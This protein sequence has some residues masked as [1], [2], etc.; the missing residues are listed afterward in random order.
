MP[1]VPKAHKANTRPQDQF[2]SLYRFQKNSMFPLASGQSSPS[3]RST[4]CRG[5]KPL[6]AYCPNIGR[7]IFCAYSSCVCINQVMTIYSIHRTPTNLM[8]FH[9]LLH[10]IEKT[11]IILSCVRLWFWFMYLCN[12]SFH[13]IPSSSSDIVRR[14]QDLKKIFHLVFKLLR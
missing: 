5:Q 9:S 2:V 12:F 4:S 1:K 14:L 6:R 11:R 7:C 13:T 10:H 3:D 8:H